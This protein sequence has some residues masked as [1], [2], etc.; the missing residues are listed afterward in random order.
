[1]KRSAILT[2]AA[3]VL[4]ASV[5]LAFAQAGK[6]AP[7][8]DEP[9]PRAPVAGAST[10][11]KKPDG[12]GEKCRDVSVRVP[13]LEKPANIWLV[14]LHDT[15]NALLASIKACNDSAEAKKVPG[16]KTDRAVILN[17][18]Q[19]VNKWANFSV[20]VVGGEALMFNYSH[21]E[22]GKIVAQWAMKEPLGTRSRVTLEKPEKA[23][24]AT[25]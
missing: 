3:V 23:I 11:D 25:C 22:A 9:N 4:A 6:P 21:C 14:F 1:M 15:D 19:G 18:S 20:P 17:V 7:L 16:S 12:A 5:S 2:A 13:S 10:P 24:P 8:T